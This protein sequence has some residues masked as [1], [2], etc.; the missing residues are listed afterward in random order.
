MR[1]EEAIEFVYPG[2]DVTVIGE[3]SQNIAE[4][5]KE[6]AVAKDALARRVQVSE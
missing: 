1:L 6:A 3:L 5:S 2:L 4:R